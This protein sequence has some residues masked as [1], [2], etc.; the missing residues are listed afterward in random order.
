MVV[1]SAQN[2]VEE[3]PDAYYLVYLSKNSGVVGKQFAEDG[4]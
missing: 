3:N 2:S 1:I 4:H